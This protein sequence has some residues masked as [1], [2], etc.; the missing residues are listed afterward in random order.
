MIIYCQTINQT[1]LVY[2]TLR[3]KL[4]TSM[5]HQGTINPRKAL[6]EM[7]H[8]C[9]PKANKDHIL[10]SFQDKYGVIRV[11]VAT[12]AFGMGIN[13]KGVQTIVHYGPS[14]N[15]ESY[16]QE[17]GRA[18]RDGQPSKV[19]L[20]YNSV[21]LIHV[22]KDIKGYLKTQSCRRQFILNF[23]NAKSTNKQDHT[24]CDVCADACNCGLPEC[25]TFASY[26]TLSSDCSKYV[27]SSHR[28][29]T[30]EQKLKVRHELLE[31]SQYLL[32]VLLGK[33]KGQAFD[34]FSNPQ[35]MLGFSHMQIKQVIENCD[36]LF[37]IQDISHYVE[38]WDI[39]HAHKIQSIL[40]NVFGDIGEQEFVSLKE[41][42]S[43]V[44]DDKDDDEQWRLLWDDFVPDEDLAEILLCESLNISSQLDVTCMDETVSSSAS[45]PDV[46]IEAIESMNLTDDDDD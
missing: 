29:V 13:C 34:S 20:L 43:D 40:Q 1:Q 10:R 5:Y 32:T 42:K 18:G 26:P 22:E 14:K 3:A 2:S 41:F 35:F 9:T 24:C 25:K 6:I 38:I 23:F 19:F 33:I 7:L 17:C 4:R 37:S 39:K 16:V 12:I 45:F 30:M 11:L 36:H 44:N 27:S 8:S 15:I 21:Q 46:A 31:Y 28:K